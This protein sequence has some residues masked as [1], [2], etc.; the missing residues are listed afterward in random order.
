MKVFINDVPF[1]ISRYDNN[2]SVIARYILTLNNDWAL[3]EHFV[4]INPDFLL[5]KGSKIKIEDIRDSFPKSLEKLKNFTLNWYSPIQI[6]I[7]WLTLRYPTEKELESALNEKLLKKLRRFDAAKFNTKGEIIRLYK[8]YQKEVIE[9]RHKLKRDLEQWDANIR[10][11]PKKS[12]DVGE[13]KTRNTTISVTLDVPKEISLL[14][15]FDSL[16]VSINVPLLVL[17]Y[18]G[19]V[20]YKVFPDIPL[21][22]RAVTFPVEEDG[23]YFYVLSTLSKEG[24]YIRG[25]WNEQNEMIVVSSV[26]EGLGDVKII[27]ILLRSLGDRIKVSI[28]QKRQTGVGGFFVAKFSF[29]SAIM[30]DLIAINPLVSNLLY[31]NELGNIDDLFKNTAT[32]KKY[33]TFSYRLWNGKTIGASITVYKSKKKLWSRV[34]I[35]KTLKS[36]VTR[37]DIEV[38]MSIFSKVA[39]LYSDKVFEISKE[40][41]K[42]VSKS[43]LSLYKP[44]VKQMEV[45]TRKTGKKLVDLNTVLPGM[46]IR[47]EYSTRCQ[48]DRQPIHIDENKLD[49]YKRT[50]RNVEIMRF[51]PGSKHYYACEG[52]Y[53]DKKFYHPGLQLN[54]MS[55]REKYPYIPCCFNPSQKT[56]NEKIFRMFGDPDALKKHA[57][58]K[59]GVMSDDEKVKGHIKDEKKIIVQGRAGIVPFYLQEIAKELGYSVTGGN[60]LSL[61]RLGVVKSPSSFIHCMGRALDPKYIE[62]DND[63]RKKYVEKVRKDIASNNFS[64]GKQ[65]LFDLTNREIKGILIDFKQYLKP[66]WFVSLVSKYYGCNIF[67]YTQSSKYPLGD[68]LIPRHTQAYLMYAIDIT[69]PTVFILERKYGG[70][71]QCELL[72]LGSK[73]DDIKTD[74]KGTKLAK[75]ALKLLYDANQVSIIGPTF[76]DIKPI[77]LS[78]YPKNSPPE[79]VISQFIDVDGKTR[80]LNYKGLSVM[81]LPLPPLDIKVDD[82]QIANWK[83]LNDF[84][85]AKNLKIISQ[86]VVDSAV[87]GVWVQGPNMIMGYILTEVNQIDNTMITSPNRNNPLGTP[88]RED[89]A[90]QKMRRSRKIAALLK[91]YTLFEYSRKLTHGSQVDLKE[92]FV[93]V[94]NHQYDLDKARILKSDNSMYQGSKIIVP[95]EQTRDKLIYY[96]KSQLL[97]DK[98]MVI[99]YKNL[100]SIQKSYKYLSD[101]RQVKNQLVFLDLDGILEWRFDKNH[102]HLSQIVHYDIM[103]GITFPY[104][105]SHPYIM[106]G[107]VVLIQNVLDGSL[108]AAIKVGKR[109]AKDQSNLGFFVKGDSD[110]HTEYVE[111]TLKKDNPKSNVVAIFKYPNGSFAAILPL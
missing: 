21:P 69:K 40:Y 48:K 41:E 13:F 32:T 16:D 52:G 57:I 53:G 19:R 67:L 77:S 9:K 75:S 95:S 8:R 71:R 97:N 56:K 74:L 73:E 54:T 109:W 87:Y 92:M 105:Y 44:K 42:F 99:G 35:K 76:N 2:S 7:L 31:M 18:K 50:H 85:K 72:I 61:L 29:N 96:L 55:N 12:I 93:V 27:N 98:Q 24:D 102:R 79:G 94:P 84:L 5:K 78:P 3:L 10:K 83:T 91:E 28:S 23:L 110:Y 82:P 22:K 64:V 104:F 1:T 90:L 80:M 66:R 6:A 107:K 11:L 20:L 58:K 45:E 49:K 33:F 81:T 47:G 100:L 68:I 65:E 25:L 38:L 46:F 39:R 88:S 106:D 14:A 60:Q 34:T 108:D 111:Y 101:F 43:Y 70:Y 103:V 4:M 63:K 37:Q 51:P 30:A 15:I 26:E 89:S 62:M 36:V 86:E 59:S 17:H